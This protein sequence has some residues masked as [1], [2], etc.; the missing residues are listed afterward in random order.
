MAVLEVSRSQA[1]SQNPLRF[2]QF[3]DSSCNSTSP[4]QGLARPGPVT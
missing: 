2:K 3:P 1:S 4:A